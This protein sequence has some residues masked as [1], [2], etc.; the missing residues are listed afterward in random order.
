MSVPGRRVLLALLC[1]PGLLLVEVLPGLAFTTT[2]LELGALEGDG[3]NAAGLQLQINLLDDSHAHVQ[4]LA[5]TALLPE[6]LGEI[7]DLQ[8]ECSAAELTATRLDCRDGLL[9]LQSEQHGRQQI[10]TRFGYRF[11]DQ[12]LS[13]DLDGISLLGGRV[14]ARGELAAGSWNIAI[15]AGGLSLPQLSTRLA[16]AGMSL[17]RLDGSGKIGL[18]AQLQGSAAVLESAGFSLHLQADS[19]TDADGSVA[20][21]GL[22]ATVAGNARAVT[23]GWR[24]DL[25]INADR[26]ML[27]I[28]PLFLEVPAQAIQAT[29]HLDYQVDTRQVTLHALEYRHP[30]SVVL[31][32]N[33]HIEL[34]KG[35]LLRELR[36]ELQEGVFASFYPTY[37]RPWF[38]GTMLGALDTAGR[39]NGDLHW[40]QGEL[41]RVSLDLA[42]LSLHDRE[43]RFDLTGVNGRLRWSAG[44]EEQVS[45]LHWLNGSVY[46]VGLGQADLKVETTGMQARLLEPAR[47][48]VLDGELQL[49]TFRLE[50][51][52]AAALRWEVDGILT[53]VSMRQL[54]LALGWPEFAG[55]LSGVIPAVRY[56]DG[57]LS[58]G[59]I[60]LMKVFDGMVTLENVQLERPF[61]V[62]PRLQLDARFTDIDL[63]AMT[64]AFSF[65]RIEGRLEGRIDDLEMESWRPVSFDAAFATPAGDKSRHRISQRA[66][67]NISSIGGGGVGGALSRSFLRV[68][69]DF[70]YDRLGIRCRLE[71]GICDMGGVAPAASAGGYYLV[72]GRLLPP[73][74]DVIGYADRVDWE[75]LLAQ[76]MAVTKQQQNTGME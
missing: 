30:G 43:G 56:D 15:D 5:Q 28:E 74:L 22:D 38:A 62:I 42:D 48:Q 1:L 4:L 32:A 25:A 16:A 10:R 17:P 70:P 14:A 57:H 68:F 50:V 31:A 45:D 55:K 29:A 33:G 37:L 9:Q 41:D 64:G 19:F 27:Y 59:G 67:D 23:G 46:R 11:A 13:F 40:R 20:G 18:T 12:Q 7:S 76:I 63:E 44:G 6:P 3:W 51:G 21:E 47:I 71:N 69:E 73:R 52:E 35:P 72:K 34:D 66:V 53:P 8:L 75:T 39:I 49:E 61:G 54:S 26:G 58:V 65:G 36:V 24:L 2:T 60:L